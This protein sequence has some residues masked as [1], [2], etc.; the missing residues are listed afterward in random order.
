[1]STP[2]TNVEKEGKR[3]RPSLIAIRVSALAALVM[4]GAFLL[5][6]ANTASE[7]ATETSAAAPSAEQ[8]QAVVAQLGN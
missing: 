1:M 2:D 8:V 5:S 6:I 7:D 3:Q 4:L